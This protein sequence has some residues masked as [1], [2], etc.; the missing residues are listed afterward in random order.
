MSTPDTTRRTGRDWLS[1]AV[2][3][4]ALVVAIYLALQVIGFMFKLLF[5]AAVV[6]IGLAAWRAWREDT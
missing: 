4:A 6:V 3:V 2:T 5:V 1:L